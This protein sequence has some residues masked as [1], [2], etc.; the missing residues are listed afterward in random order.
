MQ[1]ENVIE[2][3]QDHEYLS[4]IDSTRFFDPLKEILN[5]FEIQEYDNTGMNYQN[6]GYAHAE[7]DSH[8]VEEIWIRLE[9]GIDDMGDGCSEH[10]S[11]IYKIYIDTV[12]DNSLSVREKAETIWD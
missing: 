7:Y 9:W 11:E 4:G 12:L 5:K 10:H 8:D 2:Q 1:Q 6:G 3:N